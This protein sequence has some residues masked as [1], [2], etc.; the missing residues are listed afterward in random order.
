MEQWDLYDENR[1][2]LHRVVNR[3]EALQ[4]GEYHVVVGIWVFGSGQRIL[5]T[6]RSPEKRFAPGK[7]ENTGGHVMAGETSEDAV[8]RELREETGLYARR[9]DV[10]FLGSVRV[11]PFFG[12]NFAVHLDADLGA[13]TLQPGETCDVKWVTKEE[14]DRMA[15]AG[16]LAPSVVEHLLPLRTA[17]EAALARL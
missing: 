14:F 3:D 10:T 17:W 8:L 2:S 1:V 4:P 13:V 15:E 6:K 16:E 12:D 9:E 7:W 5:L 11:P